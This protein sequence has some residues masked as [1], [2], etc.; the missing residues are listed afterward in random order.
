MASPRPGW[1]PFREPLWRTVRRNALIALAVGAVV[2][3]LKHNVRLLVPYSVLALWF[4]LGGH[5][6][7]VL[8]LNRIR[9]RIGGGRTAQVA[10]RVVVW[11]LGGI[12]LFLAITATA[13]ALPLRRPAL[14]FWWLAGLL[15]IAVELVAHTVLAV[16]DQPNFY[17]GGG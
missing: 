16:R 8:F 17:G 13:Q 11:Y 6:V 15:F 2:S 5:Y 3:A 14:A 10:A 4:S 1:T 9:P 12:V 7:E